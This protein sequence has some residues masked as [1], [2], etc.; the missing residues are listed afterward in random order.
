VYFN[1]LSHHP[2]PIQ[3]FSNEEETWHTYTQTAREGTVQ[4][5]KIVK[6]CVLVQCQCSADRAFTNWEA[7]EV[8]IGDMYN[9]M[10]LT[11]RLDMPA[12]NTV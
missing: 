7:V 6:N 3:L 5:S 10:L 4:E 9:A 2:N 11:T 12:Q 8:R 1:T